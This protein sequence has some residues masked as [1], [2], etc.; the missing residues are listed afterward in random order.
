MKPIYMISALGLGLLLAGCTTSTKVQEM[1]DASY[2]DYQSQLQAHQESIDVLKQSAMASLEKSASNTV[3]IEKIEEQIDNM[4]TQMIIVQ[5]LANA[6]KVMSAANTVK[7]SDIEDRLSGYIETNSKDLSRMSDIDQLYEEV[8]ISQFKQISASANAAIEA[9]A[10]NG[11]SATT[12]T[13]I[14]LDEPIEI[15]A[16]DTTTASP[17]ND[18][19]G[20]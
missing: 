13:P 11:Y 14:D 6:A 1:I 9:L 15:M 5:D 7:V 10:S 8:L 16:P 19:P 20:E 17:T 4:I 18:T 2:Q 12:N 3:R